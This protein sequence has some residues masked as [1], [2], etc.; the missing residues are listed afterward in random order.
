LPGLPG[1]RRDLLAKLQDI[2]PASNNRKPDLSNNCAG[3]FEYDQ[4]ALVA[5]QIEDVFF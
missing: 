4:G 2:D 1:H 5:I 3:K